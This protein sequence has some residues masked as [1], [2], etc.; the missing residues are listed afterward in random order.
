M[1]HHDIGKIRRRNDGSIVLARLYLELGVYGPLKDQQCIRSLGNNIAVGCRPQRFLKAD[2]S[3]G[4]Q[5]TRSSTFRHI[6]ASDSADFGGKSSK[7]RPSRPG[8]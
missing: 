8:G 2:S 6:A 4:S 3:T 7:E 5:A 1:R